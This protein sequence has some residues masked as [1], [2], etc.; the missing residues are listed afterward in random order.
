MGSTTFWWTSPSSDRLLLG[1][2]SDS[3]IVFFLGSTTFWWTFA[4]LHREHLSTLTAVYYF[5][6]RT[7]STSANGVTG[8]FGTGPFSEYISNPYYLIFSMSIINFAMFITS[9]SNDEIA[10]V[11]IYTTT[12]LII[13]FY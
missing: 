12:L 7:M 9:L 11:H 8:A 2:Y 5:K 4:G 3:G 13:F 1:D 6:Q 10:C